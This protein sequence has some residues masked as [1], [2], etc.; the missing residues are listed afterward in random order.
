MAISDDEVRSMLQGQS[1]QTAQPQADGQQTS[2][3]DDQVKQILFAQEQPQQE[4]DGGLSIEQSVPEESPISIVDRMRLSFADDAGREE[5]LKKK[6]KFVA[7]VENGKYA[8]GDD[9]RSLTP[10]DPEGVFNDVLGDIADV[11]AEIPV[12]AGQIG[13]AAAGIPGGPGGVI[14]GGAAG[15][16]AGEGV[17]KGIGKMLGVNKQDPMAVATDMAISAA[18]GA[19]G[20]SLGQI[21]GAVTK[22]VVSPA[23][24]KMLDDIV[25]QRTLA[26]KNPTGAV[27]ALAKIVN[28]AAGVDE[29]ATLIAGKYGFG[30]TFSKHNMDKATVGHIANDLVGSAAAKERELSQRVYTAGHELHGR[31]QGQRV[32][33]VTEVYDRLTQDL[34]EIGLLESGNIMNRNSPLPGKGFFRSLLQELSGKDALQVSEPKMGRFGQVVGKRSNSQFLK[35]E[36]K[37]TVKQALQ[38]RRAYSNAFD[39]LSPIEQSIAYRALNGEANGAVKGLSHQLD[40]IAQKVKANNFLEAN[41]AFNGF[42]NVE[43]ALRSSGLSIKDPI[44]ANAFLQNVDSKLSLSLD[45]FKKLDDLLPTKVYDRALMW[46]AA[47]KF[48]SSNPNLLRFAMIGGILGAGSA[49]V[50]GGGPV[51]RATKLGLG[52]A[53]GSPSG[54]RTLLRL[55]EGAG[56]AATTGA[57]KGARFASTPGKVRQ[58]ADAATLSQLARTLYTR[59]QNNGK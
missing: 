9:P 41:E 10:I 56:R 57:I 20:E 13:G 45:A 2:I 58:R 52:I 34:K 46:N 50:G 43:K 33:E 12:I 17:K 8:V 25:T 6:F 24:T 47:Q 35:P 29:D 51:E 38:I 16:F 49:F 37:I 30:K 32:V 40:T 54:L 26:G 18:F 3:S 15:S 22:N 19:A 11:V 39:N 42:K 7:K 31:T 23:L 5:E 27:K 21:A 48:S 14:A 59:R 4:A 1:T 55:S 53:L 28:I 36:K 44:S